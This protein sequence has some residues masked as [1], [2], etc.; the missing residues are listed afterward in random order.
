M[1]VLILGA[2][3]GGICTAKYLLKHAKK[4]PNLEIT[5][6]D[7]NTYHFFTP[8]LHEVCVYCLKTKKLN[9]TKVK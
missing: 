3:F 5:V 2:G 4:M 6:I 7:R 9:F 1:R 8:F